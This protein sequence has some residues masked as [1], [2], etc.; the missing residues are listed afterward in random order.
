M[1]ELSVFK[2]PKPS[3]F[4]ATYV[5]KITLFASQFIVQTSEFTLHM[6]VLQCIVFKIYARQ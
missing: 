2:P 4:A 6:L 5:C 3:L 1:P